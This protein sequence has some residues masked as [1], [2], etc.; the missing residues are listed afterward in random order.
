V[1]IGEACQEEREQIKGE[2]KIRWEESGAFFGM[3]YG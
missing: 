2:N 1:T 3:I